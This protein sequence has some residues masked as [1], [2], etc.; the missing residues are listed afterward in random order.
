MIN[1]NNISNFKN[2]FNFK[3]IIKT[4]DDKKLTINT[5]IIFEFT[6][7]NNID[8]N[9]IFYYTFEIIMNLIYNN[10]LE[11][12]LIDIYNIDNKTKIINKI[13]EINSDLNIISINY[14]ED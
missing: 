4:K 1:I 6:K 5:Y 13:K 14:I 12:N 10:I 8:E 7:N 11:H 2:E 9:Y 3:N